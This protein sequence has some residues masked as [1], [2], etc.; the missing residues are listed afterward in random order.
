EFTTVVPRRVEEICSLKAACC[1]GRS[2][3]RMRQDM[4]IYSIGHSNHNW[5]TFYALL[6]EHGVE[7]LVDTRTKPTSKWAP[8]ASARTL[9]GLTQNERIEYV[10]M[11][12]SLGGKP[13]DRSSYDARGKPDYA[14]IR[15]K[16]FF[17]T[18]IAELVNM[19][20]SARVALMCAEEDPAKCHRK[21]LIGPA[22]E[23]VGVTLLHIRQDGS[24]QSSGATGSKKAYQ[25]Q[26]QGALP[27][28][29]VDE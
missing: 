15:S 8:F 11:G 12:D 16:E 26:L 28:E 25:Q 3:G 2:D 1:A 7:V 13:A 22:L 18:A 14:R 10:F 21:L 5:D 6:R 20:A 24:V 29:V 9:P 19:A 27:L 17:K 4:V 23:Q